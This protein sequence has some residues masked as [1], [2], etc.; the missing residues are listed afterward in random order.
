MI[1]GAS[2]KTTSE[3]ISPCQKVI[4]CSLATQRWLSKVRLTGLMVNSIPMSFQYWMH[5]SS[6]GGISPCSGSNSP[7]QP[8]RLPEGKSR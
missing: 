3:P 5:S 4:I 6:V 8:M 7:T 2:G 1:L